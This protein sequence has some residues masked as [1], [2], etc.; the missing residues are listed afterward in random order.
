MVPKHSSMT[1]LFFLFMIGDVLTRVMLLSPNTPTPLRNSV[2]A[3][4]TRDV[5]GLVLIGGLAFLLSFV[6]MWCFR[7][8]SSHQTKVMDYH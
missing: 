3:S 7:I 5:L 8:A 2:A 6:H 1:S 4:I